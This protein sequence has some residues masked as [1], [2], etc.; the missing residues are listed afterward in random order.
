MD[1]TRTLLLEADSQNSIKTQ[2]LGVD[3]EDL[4]SADRADWV[5]V[6]DSIN[7]QPGEFAPFHTS[8][9]YRNPGRCR[10]DDLALGQRLEFE[11]KGVEAGMANPSAAL[12][13]AMRITAEG[14]GAVGM[15]GVV[16]A[17]EPWNA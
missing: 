6:Y 7:L 11:L 3:S 4:T 12:Y 15:G 13:R 9:L 5:N 14:G 10:D 2:A 17:S 8:Q 1:A 16:V